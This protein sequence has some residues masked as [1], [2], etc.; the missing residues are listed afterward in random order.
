MVEIQSEICNGCGIC[1]NVCPNGLFVGKEGGLSI[2][3]I[4]ANRDLCSECGHCVL[5][6]PQGAVRHDAI[7]DDKI[8]RRSDRI[9]NPSDIE[10]L[11]MERRSTR[12]FKTDA[13]PKEEI[14][15]LIEV[16]TNAGT[17]SNMQSE[18]FIVIQDRKLLNRLEEMTIDI[19]WDK[20][21]KYATDRSMVGR[22]LAKRYPPERFSNLKRYHD[23]IVERR[24]GKQV[25]GMV[26][27]KAPCL[28]VMCGFKTEHLSPV[29]CALAIRNMELLATAKGLGAC[30]AGLLINA[31]RMDCK[32]INAALQIDGSHRVFGAL[33]LGYPRH[34]PD[35]IVRRK[36]REVRWL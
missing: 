6:C 30:W 20:G 10:Q 23:L 11:M 5:H 15:S 7:P 18:Y 2:E 14:E 16:A 24:N 4:V 29:N 34:V 12:Y 21:L 17:A 32:K 3:F 13:V 25:E 9:I 33:M 19:L 1:A 26:F 22:L 31:A 8:L 28:I 36:P 27:R 35:R